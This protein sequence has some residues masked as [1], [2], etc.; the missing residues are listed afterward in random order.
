VSPSTHDDVLAALPG[1]QRRAL[2]GLRAVIRH[3]APEAVETISYG[4]AAFKLDGRSLVSYGAAK[5]HCSLYV[6]SP[7]V[8]TAFA[9]ELADFR[10]TRGSIQFTP[11]RP[12][13]ERLVTAIVQARVAEVRAAQRRQ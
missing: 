10:L 9:S 6:Q 12:I 13:P 3:A 2:E 11:D 5:S 8:V 4:A 7:A 1:D